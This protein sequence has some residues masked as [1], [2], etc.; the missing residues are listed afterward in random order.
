[1]RIQIY[2]EN[3]NWSCETGEIIRHYYDEGGISDQ[4]MKEIKRQTTQLAK[5]VS[6]DNMPNHARWDKETKELFVVV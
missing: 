2:D 4:D 5:K 1:M 6:D 3:G